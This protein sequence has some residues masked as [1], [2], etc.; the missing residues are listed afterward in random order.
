M[1]SGMIDHIHLRAHDFAQTIAFYRA[2][3]AA[4]GQTVE[5]TEDHLSCGELWIDA[6]DRDCTPTHVHLAFAAADRAAVQRF[7]AAG[8]AAGGINN[9][10]PGFRNYGPGYYAA[11]LIDPNGNNVEAVHRV[12]IAE[13]ASGE[14]RR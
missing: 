3:L 9:G 12:S 5:E 11:F 4:L 14:D 8:L 6:A 1:T 13:L 2:T 7:H 10:S